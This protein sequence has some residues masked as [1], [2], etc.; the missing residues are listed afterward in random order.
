MIN[1]LST[2]SVIP[3]KRTTVHDTRYLAV[4]CLFLRKV[5]AKNLELL[6]QDFI[7]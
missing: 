7:E 3:G 2:H 1:D 6:W 4:A 5:E